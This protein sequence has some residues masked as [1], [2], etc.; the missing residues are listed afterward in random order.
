MPTGV[1]L[2]RKRLNGRRVDTAIADGL[3]VRGA[4]EH[5]V[6]KNLAVVASVGRRCLATDHGDVIIEADVAGAEILIEKNAPRGK[7]LG[8]ERSFRVRT[9]GDVEA[10]VFQND[11]KNGLD[12][13]IDGTTV[14]GRGSE[15]AGK[16]RARV[17]RTGWR[18][19]EVFS[20]RDSPFGREPCAG[21]AR[22]LRH[23]QYR[24]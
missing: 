14:I 11:Y 22:G 8:E 23:V 15:R 24:S 16:E 5:E 3:A 18:C 17:Q 21:V 13:V 12:A 19:G 20:Q 7:R 6:C 10:F 2:V 1:E 9:E 4:G